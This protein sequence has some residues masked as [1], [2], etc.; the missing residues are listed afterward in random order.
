MQSII[1]IQQLTWISL[2]KRLQCYSASVS[3][4]RFFFVL[5]QGALVKS[6]A[7]GLRHFDCFENV[8]VS[9]GA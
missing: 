8:Y 2:L 3:Q 4:T 1:Y 5:G 9:C 6:V 7:V